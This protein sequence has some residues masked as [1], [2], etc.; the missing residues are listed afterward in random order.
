MKNELIIAI[1]QYQVE[2]EIFHKAGKAYLNAEKGKAI[3]Q[4]RIAVLLRDYI[5][6]R[7]NIVIIRKDKTYHFNKD[8]ELVIG[9]VLI[10]E[11]K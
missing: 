6:E 1:D 10:K 5:A 4:Q 8:G 7:D 2:C 3:S 11:K 9:E